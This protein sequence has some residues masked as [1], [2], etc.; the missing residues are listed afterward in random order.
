MHSKSYKL[1]V[2][3]GLNRNM[4]SHKRYKIRVCSEFDLYT[5]KFLK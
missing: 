5:I 2:K 4:N 1:L 3:L